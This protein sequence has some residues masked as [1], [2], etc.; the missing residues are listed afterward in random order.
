MYTRVG[1]IASIL[2]E[3]LDVKDN[4]LINFNDRDLVSSVDN[5]C[6]SVMGEITAC[7]NGCE[8]KA[9]SKR[10]NIKVDEGVLDSMDKTNL[11][12]AFV[13]TCLFVMDSFIYEIEKNLDPGVDRSMLF[14]EEFMSLIKSKKVDA[15]LIGLKKSCEHVLVNR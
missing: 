5:F 8:L 11:F 15:M 7:K 1:T 4:E 10:L 9:L 3:I 12:T 14:G 6:K 2:A 13:E